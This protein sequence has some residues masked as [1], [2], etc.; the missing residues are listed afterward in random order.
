MYELIIEKGKQ[1]SNREKPKCIQTKPQGK[2][3]WEMFVKKIKILEY[4]IVVIT[5]A[6]PGHSIAK[7]PCI[8]ASRGEGSEV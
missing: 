4:N 2:C 8:L 7:M 5:Q 6:S 1:E 3:C